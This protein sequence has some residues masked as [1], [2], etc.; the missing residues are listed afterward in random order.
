MDKQNDKKLVALTEA[1][2]PLYDYNSTDQSKR[3][4]V[5]TLQNSTGK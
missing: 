1:R 3:N 5:A 4:Q 2:R